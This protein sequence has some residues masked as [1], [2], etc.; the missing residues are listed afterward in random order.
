MAEGPLSPE[1]LLERRLDPRYTVQVP[2]ALVWGDERYEGTLRNLSTRGLYLTLQVG[3]EELRVE[4]RVAVVFG[5]PEESCDATIV[6]VAPA[7]GAEEPVGVGILL[8]EPIDIREL[9][10]RYL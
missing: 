2:A 4:D 10:E 8:H 3:A 7:E 1:E 5:E 9:S 6:H